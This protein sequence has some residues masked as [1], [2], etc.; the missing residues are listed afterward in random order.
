MVKFKIFLSFFSPNQNVTSMKSR[1]HPRPLLNQF[2]LRLNNSLNN[3]QILFPQLPSSEYV[4]V[5]ALYIN[6]PKV[7]LKEQGKPQRLPPSVQGFRV[8][9]TFRQL[10]L[11]PRA[12]FRCT[13]KEF[14]RSAQV[15]YHLTILRLN[16]PR[17]Q[18]LPGLTNTTFSSCTNFYPKSRLNSTDLAF[19]P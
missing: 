14:P 19:W 3:L 13:L 16:I 4:G 18:C 11:C 15:Q 12:H 1:P 8:P 6:L 5:E 2:H 10:L 7:C 17:F 9:I